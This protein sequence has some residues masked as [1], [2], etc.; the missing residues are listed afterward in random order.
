MDKLAEIKKWILSRHPEVSDIE[1]D[2][3]LLDNRL[4]DSLSFVEFVLT[5]EE[6]SG[7]AVDMNSIEIDHF[8]TLNSIGSQ[9]FDLTRNG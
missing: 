6:L 7:R 5:I 2:F 4:V 3:D 8:R 1:P 9:F